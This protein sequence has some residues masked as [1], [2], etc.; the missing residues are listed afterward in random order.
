MFTE[1]TDSCSAA[2]SSPLEIEIG[3]G[4]VVDALVDCSD[5]DSDTD[6]DEQDSPV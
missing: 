3:I 5:F 4:I 1:A 6:F 2:R